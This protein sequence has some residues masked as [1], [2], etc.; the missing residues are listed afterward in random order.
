[1]GIDVVL[2]CLN[3]AAALPWVLGRMPDG[4]RPIVV[5]NGSTDGSAKIAV[6]LGATV[7]CEPHRGFGAA[8]HAGLVAAVSDVVCFMDADASLDP[9]QLP[10]VSGPVVAG[11]ADL[12]LGRRVL[13]PGASW[14]VHAR[15][16]NA[17]LAR[18]LRRRTSASLHDLGPMRA[19][20]RVA[21][22]RLELVDRR[23]GYPLEMVLRAGAA[24]WRIRETEVDYLPRE[25]RSKVTGTVRGT[26]RAIGDMRRV[27]ARRDGA[28]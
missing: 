9:Q 8:C 5:D 17:M 11:E 3:E 2:P 22:L 20:G 27:M 4:F 21:L 13:R 12:V 19:C 10:R 14:P 7:V 1:M 18:R 28:A 23:F 24:G 25:G 6:G 15:L 26:L 16:G